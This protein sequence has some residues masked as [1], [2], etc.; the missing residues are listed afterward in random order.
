MG[1][2]T[3]L[4]LTLL[5]CLFLVPASSEALVYTPQEVFLGDPLPIRIYTNPRVQEVTIQI[6]DD[7]V[8]K[9]LLIEG[10][11][12][13]IREEEEATLWVGLVGIPTVTRPG[14]YRIEIRMG[15]GAQVVPLSVLGK[16]FIHEEI[17]LNREMTKLRTEEDARKV[18]EM[19]ELL[20]RVSQFNVQSIHQLKPFRMPVEGFR[21]TSLFGD[22]RKYRY[23]DGNMDQSIHTGIDFATPRGTPVGASAAGRVAFAGPRI[24]TGNTVVLEHL[25][26]VY[27]LYYHLD[28]IDV[29]EGNQVKEGERI[30]TSG[31]T[32][33][34]TG[35][36][37]HWEVRVG[38][39]PVNPDAFLQ[40]GPLDKFFQLLE[41]AVEL[42]E[43]R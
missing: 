38:G 23:A 36:H 11:A 12:F 21:R 18:K 32:G 8:K 5:F 42:K 7:E 35:P 39:I 26:G 27:T 10:K 17:A 6:W 43:G 13:R 20:E 40:T 15:E 25:P 31:A 34:I 22:R 14:S 28:R 33:L 30:G 19:K 37:L 2:R 1:K 29:K 16:P 3:I 24:L 9:T 41:T 4:T